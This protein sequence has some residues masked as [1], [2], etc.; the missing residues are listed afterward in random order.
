MTFEEEARD[1]QAPWVADNIERA[2]RRA[3]RLRERMQEVRRG[4]I[5]GTYRNWHAARCLQCL[6]AVL[7]CDPATV[8]ASAHCHELWFR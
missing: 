3:A 2:Q 1:L 5:A 8:C 7:A 6:S 4:M